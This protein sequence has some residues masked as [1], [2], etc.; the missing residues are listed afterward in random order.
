MP[1]G[2]L[3]PNL[4]GFGSVN[5]LAVVLVQ[6]NENK[7]LSIARTDDSTGRTEAEAVKTTLDE[8]ELTDQIIAIGKS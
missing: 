5:R 6:E 4:G 2:K 1:S 8:W 7:I 3:L